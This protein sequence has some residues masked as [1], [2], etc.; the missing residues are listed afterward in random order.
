MRRMLP[1]R[2]P[3]LS[4]RTSRIKKGLKRIPLL[5]NS[6]YRQTSIDP[7][8]IDL[9]YHDP[10]GNSRALRLLTTRPRTPKNGHVDTLPPFR[11]QP[12][13]HLC[14]VAMGP[15]KG[16]QKKGQPT[17]HVAIQGK[18]FRLPSNIFKRF[19][20]TQNNSNY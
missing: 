6:I 11:W 14:I 5:I 9:P 12:A 18:R 20:N 2:V 4:T 3:D 10:G 19:P 13:L 16:A 17:S 15:Q 7:R 8:S 1:R